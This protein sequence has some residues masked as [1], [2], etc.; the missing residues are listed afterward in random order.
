[1]ALPDYRELVPKGSVTGLVS[2]LGEIALGTPWP[3]WPLTVGGNIQVNLPEYRVLPAPT[4]AAAP[5]PPPAGGSTGDS[6]AIDTGFLPR[7]ELT[8]KLN[9][10]VAASIGILTM[11][12]LT[13]KGVEAAGRIAKGKF[14]GGVT[15][16]EVFSGKVTL[17]NT[18]V[19][20]LE[21][22]P[23]IQGNVT[24]EQ[25]VVQ[26]ALGFMKPEYTTMATGRASGHSVFA[27]RMPSDARFMDELKASGQ[28][29]LEPITLNTVQVG[30]MINDMISKVPVLKLP[31][32]KV[33]PLNGM[34]KADYT[35]AG[36]T[37]NLNPL[38]GRDADGSELELKGKVSLPTMHGDLV[39][40]FMWVNPQAKGCVMEGNSDDQGRLIVPIALKGNL[41]KPEVNMVTDMVNK[42][43][44]RALECEKKKIVEQIKKDGGKKLESEAK[45][46]LKGILGN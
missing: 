36:Q 13:I 37:V 14:F 19:P 7:G 26:D 8:E 11:E 4:G 21:G 41:M 10:Q 46:V 1:M 30:K 45:K 25:I 31:P 42:L 39:G 43:V 27:T 6:P 32:A 15:L 5:A 2:V 33:A 40:N 18:E 29:T 23:V 34:V 16:R 3:T 9:M 20:L 44:G 38:I 12:P 28:I 24:I 35:L 17:T 22:R